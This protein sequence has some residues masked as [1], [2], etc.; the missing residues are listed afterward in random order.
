M[1]K[2]NNSTGLIEAGFCS[3]NNHQNCAVLNF[4]DKQ[5]CFPFAGNFNER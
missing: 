3:K 4:E 5:I 1:T 2:E